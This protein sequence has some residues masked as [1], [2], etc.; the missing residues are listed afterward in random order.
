MPRPAVTLIELTVVA[1]I[2]SAGLALLLPALQHVRTG[3][4]RLSC[5]NR[6]RQIATAAHTFH[7]LHGRL[8]ATQTWLVEAKDYF[9]Q[10]HSDLRSSVA[11]LACP[12]DP[13]GLVDYRHPSGS[14]AGLTWYVGTGSTTHSRGDGLIVMPTASP[15]VRLERDVPDGVS[16]TIL[17]TERP[18]SP[19]LLIGMWKGT[20]TRDTLA[21]VAETGLVSS[22]STGTLGGTPCPR[23]ARFAPQQPGDFCA[24]NSI[25]S[26]HPGGANFAFGDGSVRFLTH[27]VA[28]PLPEGGGSILSAL[29]TR[30][31]FESVADLW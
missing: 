2:I 3:A 21:G 29:V 6:L 4:Y 26:H 23:P 24:T 5:Q 13:R 27:A 11:V 12:A 28:E 17:A 10:G 30:G 25:W 22:T 19:N 20:S 7:S 16:Q 8:P 18:P 31:G 14:A 9:E 1:A 15:G